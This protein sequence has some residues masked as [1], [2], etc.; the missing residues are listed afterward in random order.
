MHCGSK[1]S[2]L[3]SVR[4]RDR[5]VRLKVKGRTRGRPPSFDADAYKERNVVERAFNRLKQWRG[6]ATR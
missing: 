1:E 3:Q 6:V 2:E 4:K 5:I